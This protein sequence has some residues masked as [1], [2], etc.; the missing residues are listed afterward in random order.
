MY[1]CRQKS[2]TE[3]GSGAAS[4]VSDYCLLSTPSTQQ[5]STINFEKIQGRFEALKRQKKE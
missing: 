1:N 5:A 3:L 4:V 2:K